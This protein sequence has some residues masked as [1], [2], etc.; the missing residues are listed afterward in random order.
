MFLYGI[1]PLVIVY[2]FVSASPYRSVLWSVALGLLACLP[3]VLIQFILRFGVL[4]NNNIEL[5][6]LFWYHLIHDYVV[7]SGFVLLVALVLKWFK[8]VKWESFAPAGAFFATAFGLMLVI[9][10]AFGHQYDGVYEFVYRPLTLT[11]LVVTVSFVVLKPLNPLGWLFSSVVMGA[12]AFMAAFVFTI[13]PFMAV[14][15][16]GGMIMV[17]ALFWFITRFLMRNKVSA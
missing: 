15:T 2:C 4:N 10:S 3:I 14:V 6:S 13:N 12:G 1:M 7:P 16:A 8:L 11:G 17:V 5:S 9:F